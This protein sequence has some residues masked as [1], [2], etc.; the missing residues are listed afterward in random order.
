[1]TEQF[2]QQWLSSNNVSAVQNALEDGKNA[3]SK[4]KR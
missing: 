4:K 2:G 1:M 3:T